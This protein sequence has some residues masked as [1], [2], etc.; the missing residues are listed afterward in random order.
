[1]SD[2]RLAPRRQASL[3]RVA[4]AFVAVLLTVL[5]Q[6]GPSNG[7]SYFGNIS[8][9]SEI[10]R[11]QFIRWQATTEPEPRILVVDIDE[12]SLAAVGPWPWSSSRIADLV[13]IL[14][15]RY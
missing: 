13:E 15:S 2:R 12:A 3:A 11:D 8:F 14:L 1:M 9:G 4:I 10:L 7:L 5:A 6:W